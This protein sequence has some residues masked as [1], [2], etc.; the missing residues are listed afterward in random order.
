VQHRHAAVRKIETERMPAQTLA[1]RAV[2]EQNGLEVEVAT[3]DG[4]GTYTIAGVYPGV[5]E[6]QAGSYV[7]MDPGY[8]KLVSEFDLAF[9]ARC[10]VLSRPTTQDAKSARW[11]AAQVASVRA[12]RPVTSST[13]RSGTSGAAT[14]SDQ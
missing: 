4:T 1:T 10:T 9:H 11:S 2:L 3:G 14:V 13:V 7:Y 5:T 12:G 6:H 8:Q